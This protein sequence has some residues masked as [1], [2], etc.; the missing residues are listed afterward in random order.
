MKQKSDASLSLIL[1][2]LSVDLEALNRT[3]LPADLNNNFPTNA[4]FLCDS[5]R[6]MDISKIVLLN[7]SDSSRLID[8]F[9]CLAEK[10]ILNKVKHW[11]WC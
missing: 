1:L 9:G 10:N 6:F 5:M 4:S 11:T 2:L 3:K 8:V 7:I